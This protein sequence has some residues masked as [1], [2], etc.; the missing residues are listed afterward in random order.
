MPRIPT[1]RF[2]VPLVTLGLVAALLIIL[3][4]QGPASARAVDESC[5]DVQAVWARG[6]GQELGG[7]EYERFKSQLEDRVDSGAGGIDL[8]FYQLGA[9]TY[10]GKK[11]PAVAVAGWGLLAGA[12]AQL[13]GGYAFSYGSSV[14]AGE[15]ELLSYLLERDAKCS[16]AGT[17]YVLGGYSQGAQVIGET[18]PYLGSLRDKVVFNAL[19]GDPKLYLPEG[20]GVFGFEPACR[21]KEFSEWRRKVPNCHTDDG[22][23]GARKPYLPSGWGDRT[24]LWCADNDWICGSS[25]CACNTSGHF[26]YGDAGGYIDDAAREIVDRLRARFPGH[27][28]DL[29]VSINIIGAGT[30]GL[31]VVFVLDSTGS[32][33]GQIEQAKSFASSM[34]S[35][36]AGLRGRVALVEYRD[37]GDPFV[38]RTLSGLTSDVETFR[39]ALAPVSADGGGDT[40]EALLAA[41]MHAF[42]GL[43]WRAGATKAAVVLTDAGFHNPDVATGVTLNQVA[44]RSLEIDPVN[45]YP[46]V[47]NGNSPLYQE[48]AEL[49]SGQ[50]IDDT[51]DTQA[52]LEEA[53]QRL[54]DRPVALLTQQEYAARPGEE[55]A[56]DASGS[57]ATSGRVCPD[58]G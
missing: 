15:I 27:E 1:P 19:F 8:G 36:I 23:L 34:A 22:T 7:T 21:G 10:G 6:S 18:L 52:A 54:V 49:T 42:N 20:R 45:V 28:D 13:S 38:A 9:E 43:D 30:T 40:P 47:S 11:Y 24:G 46:V 12:G 4:I 56:F 3:G 29:D 44:A 57:Y 25:K 17:V 53:L 2:V 31:D 26:H 39:T 48:L 58:F 33:G 14:A 32:M 41:L 5:P 51:G 55:I 50:V 37:A 16:S 35:T